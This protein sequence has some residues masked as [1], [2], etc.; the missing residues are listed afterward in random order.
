MIMNKNDVKSVLEFLSNE[1]NVES[2]LLKVGEEALKIYKDFEYN[3]L[4]MYKDYNYDVI[5]RKIENTDLS[6]DDT[7]RE[8]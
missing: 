3:P 5:I 2:V 7:I 1:D 6:E 8:F 4:N